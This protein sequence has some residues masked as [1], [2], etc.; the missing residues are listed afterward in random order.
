MSGTLTDVGVIDTEELAV[1]SHKSNRG[2]FGGVGGAGIDFLS[3]WT[4]IT[5]TLVTIQVCYYG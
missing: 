2:E 5:D 4:C 3:D 1:T